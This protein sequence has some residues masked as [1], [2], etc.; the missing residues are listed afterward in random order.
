MKPYYEGEAYSIPEIIRMLRSQGLEIYSDER[1]EQVL[2]NISYSRLKNY[3]TPLM[4]NTATHHFRPGANF[5]DVYA[6]YGF[7]RRLRELIF[8]ELEKVEISIRNRMAF[9]SNGSEKGYWFINPIH[10]KNANQHERMLRHL[11][12]ELERSDNEAL[13]HFREKYENEFPPS[14]LMFEAASMGTLWTIYDELSDETLRERI[15]GFYGMPPRVFSN[16]VK[17]LVHMR[18]NCAH[19]NRIWNSTPTVK[20]ILP[21]ELGKYFPPMHNQDRYHVYMTLCIIKYFID[22]IK[23]SNSFGARLKNL[24]NNFKMV[25]PAEMGFPAGWKEMDFW[26]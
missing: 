16:W 8:H 13:L 7:D 9:A 14:W 23:P 25:D 22:T 4:D 2:S 10:F 5:E 11:K 1:A 6:L 3:F 20:A 19:H 17:H 15:A 18:N 21:D 12:G 24:V 26:K